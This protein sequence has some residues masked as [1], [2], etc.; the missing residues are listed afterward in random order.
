[1]KYLI[2]NGDDLGASRGVNR[3]IIEAHQR[4]ILTS[5]SLMVNAARSE[6]AA[7]FGRTAGEVSVGLYVDVRHTLSESAAASSRRLR[8]ELHR[9]FGRFEAVVGRSPTHLRSHH[10]RPRGPRALPHFL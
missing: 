2:V 9:Q 3:G 5:T 10:N 7:E 6:E 1:M 4:G 8:E